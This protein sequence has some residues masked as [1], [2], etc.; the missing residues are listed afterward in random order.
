[1]TLYMER[2]N[3]IC[4]TLN[5]LLKIL[6]NICRAVSHNVLESFED[7][8]KPDGLSLSRL[9][10]SS[11]PTQRGGSGPCCFSAKYFDILSSL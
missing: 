11:V 10:E 2:V 4:R 7:V 6:I 9:K 3:Q 5:K 1:M 8:D